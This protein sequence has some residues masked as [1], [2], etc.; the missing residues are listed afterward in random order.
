[1]SE[2]KIFSLRRVFQ[3]WLLLFVFAA[4]CI[5][6]GL[7]YFFQTRTA[8]N[9]MARQAILHLDYIGNQIKYIEDDLKDLKTELSE[10]LIEKARVFSLLLKYV[11]TLLHNKRFLREWSKAAGVKEVSI[12]GKDGVVI[13]AFPEEFIDTDFK[14]NSG[15]FVDFWQFWKIIS[16]RTINSGFIF[17][18][19]NSDFI[20]F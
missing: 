12:L 11:P 15:L 1:M 7:S 17:T 16:W 3:T 9:M 4:F 14:N 19:N 8:Q 2:K 5:I 6:F 18:R 20:V 13:E 10:G